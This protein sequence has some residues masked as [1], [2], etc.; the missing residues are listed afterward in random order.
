[1][2]TFQVLR[3]ADW[4]EVIRFESGHINDINNCDCCQ[5][6]GKALTVAAIPSDDPH[7]DVLLC[8]PCLRI[9]ADDVE[10]AEKA[11]DEAAKGG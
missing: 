3:D 9:I 11:A 8:A 4:G 2:P 5:K 10:L 7:C 6:C 1:M